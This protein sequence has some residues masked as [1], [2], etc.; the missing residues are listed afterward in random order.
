MASEAERDAHR[1]ATK[2][3]AYWR[4]RGYDVQISVEVRPAAHGR[5][6]EVRIVSDLVNGVPKDFDPERV[7]P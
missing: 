4:A 3:R 7:K 5:P 2:V 6:E 1:F